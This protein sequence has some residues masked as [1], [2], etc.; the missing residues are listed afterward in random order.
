MRCTCKGQI[1]ILP[2]T[3]PQYAECL[4]CKKTYTYKEYRELQADWMIKRVR[5]RGLR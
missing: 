4:K 3:D 2:S 1:I 5:E